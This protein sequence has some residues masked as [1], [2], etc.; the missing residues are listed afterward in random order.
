MI[1]NSGLN[2]LIHG[3]FGNYF[4]LFDQI[5]LILSNTRLSLLLDTELISN[6]TISRGTKGIEIRSDQGAAVNRVS[7]SP[8]SISTRRSP[9][10]ESPVRSLPLS[11]ET[12]RDKLFHCEVNSLPVL[13]LWRSIISTEGIAPEKIK[14]SAEPSAAIWKIDS[15]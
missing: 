2:H 13:P 4:V 7:N 6:G 9:P 14:C 10:R 8:L 3:K 15:L 5:I 12:A 1:T 11:V